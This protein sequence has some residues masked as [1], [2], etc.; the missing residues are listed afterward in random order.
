VSVGRNVALAW[1]PVGPS[2]SFAYEVIE[3]HV[4]DD[5]RHCVADGS[6]SLLGL[7]ATLPFSRGR[8]AALTT[9]L[10]V[11]LSEVAGGMAAMSAS[12][13]FNDRR[14]KAGT[15]IER[16]LS[17]TGPAVQSLRQCACIGIIFS[18]S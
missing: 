16:S 18:R 1:A 3:K 12:F 17:G 4:R 9:F 7:P 14:C 2:G 6:S 8:L 5:F 15:V 11:L 10:H 13:A